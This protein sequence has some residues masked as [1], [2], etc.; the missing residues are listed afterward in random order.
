MSFSEYPCLSR[1]DQPYLFFF[2]KEHGSL[3]QTGYPQVGVYLDEL[4][5]PLFPGLSGMALRVGIEVMRIDLEGDEVESPERRRPY[6]G[7]VVG[8]PDGRAGE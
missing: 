7:H 2:H 8:C 5:Y 6:Y 1:A 3:A 4:F